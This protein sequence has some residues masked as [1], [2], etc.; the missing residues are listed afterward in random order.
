MTRLEKGL[1][2]AILASG[3]VVACAG[4]LVNDN[5]GPPT[6]EGGASSDDS[7]PPPPPMG[8]DGPAASDSTTHADGGGGPDAPAAVDATGDGPGNTI[9]DGA[10]LGSCDPAQWTV[11]AS[12]TGP[13]NPAPYAVDGI[14]PSR[15]STGTAQL[16][17]QYLQVDFGGWVVLDRVILDDSFASEQGDYPRGLDVIGSGDGTTFQGTLASQMFTNPGAVV[18]MDFAPQATRAVR[19][20]LN[21]SVATIWWSVHELRFGCSVPGADAGPPGPDGGTCP[22][23]AWSAGAGISRAGWKATASMTGPNDTIAGAFDGNASTRW[24]DGTGQQG[25]ETFRIDL[26]TST[27]MSEVLLY[28]LNSNTSD[29]PS[30]YAVSLSNDDQSYTTVATGVG[31]AITAACFPTQSARYV[32]IQQIGTG[33]TSWWSVY[34]ITIMP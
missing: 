19:L 17:G 29:Y 6:P 30:A 31:A 28:L 16:P 5:G 2:L 14:L 15:W 27:S 12:V 10:T 34:E 23:P 3:L 11:T 20:Q 26:G 21:S 32:K 25:G 8:D 18:A 33:Y 9:P 22:S 4:P 1:G 7:S 13:N 24:S